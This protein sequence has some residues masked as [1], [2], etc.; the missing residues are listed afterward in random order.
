MKK[1]FVLSNMYPSQTHLS[2]GIF[3][4]NQIKALDEKGIEVL[5]GVNSDT[6]VGKINVLKKYTKWA[7][8]ILLVT[9]KNSKHIG[10]SHAHYVFPTG[11]LTLLLKKAFGIPYI[12]TAHGGDINKMAK[13]NKM[14]GKLT[15]QILKESSHII[16][17]GGQLADH[18]TNDYDVPMDK[19]SIM[20][21]G[22]NREIFKEGSQLEARKLLGIPVEPIV[23]LF[24][25]NLIKEKGLKELIQAFQKLDESNS[26]L[27]IVGSKKSTG[28]VEEIYS[29]I[30]CTFKNRITFID[31][32]PQSKLVTWFQASNVFVLPS[33][34]E[35]FGLVALEALA[36]KVPVIASNVGGLT[37]LLKDGAGHLIEPQDSESLYLEMK[38]AFHSSKQQYLNEEAS[39]K[40]VR[41][42]DQ[43]ILTT[44]LIELYRIHSKI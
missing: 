30:E 18:I 40:V 19:V 9:V 34:I 28:F 20:S 29:S 17:V 38:H 42:N 11:L 7:I 35:G 44:K 21:M 22:V 12:V 8:S 13:K 6:S 37:H 4:K 16:A 26:L 39:E 5:K 25:G 24:V 31:P 33:Y 10:I 14:I 1:V 43:E 32:V 27:Y 3:V 15:H 41:E 2:F 23:Y 36:C